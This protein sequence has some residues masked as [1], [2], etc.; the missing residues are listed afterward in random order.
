[1]SKTRL[2]KGKA[3]KIANLAYIDNEAMQKLT[4]CVFEAMED[5][6]ED[7][8]SEARACVRLVG[9][10]KVYEGYYKAQKSKAA[11]AYTSVVY[12]ITKRSLEK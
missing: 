4:Q 6:S 9:Y 5:E 11:E 10:S 2:N 3:I 1:M 12:A 8:L 7:W